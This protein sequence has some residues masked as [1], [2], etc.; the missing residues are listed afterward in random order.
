MSQTQYRPSQVKLCFVET[1][2][3]HTCDVVTSDFETKSFIIQLPNFADM[4]QLIRN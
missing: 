1:P 2:T 3:L 4:C